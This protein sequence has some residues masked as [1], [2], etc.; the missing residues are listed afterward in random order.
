MIAAI[1]DIDGTLLPD[2][3]TDRLFLKYLFQKKIIGPSHLFRALWFMIKHIP[4]GTDYMLKKNKAYLKGVDQ[5]QVQAAARPFFYQV[6][7]PLIP[8]RSYD[9]VRD[10]Q[11]QGHTI[12]LL[13]AAYEP[14]VDLW[15]EELEADEAISTVVEE[16]HG[17]LTGTI[18]GE[19]P[20]A[21]G[22]AYWLEFMKKKY[23]LDLAQCYG[24]GDH[25]SDRFFLERV[26][27][28]VVVKPDKRLRAYARAKNWL[29]VDRL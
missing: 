15:K 4:Q 5:K 18:V 17:R 2:Y 19:H 3:S 7:Q 14:L 21:H 10:H 24:Y 27:H 23:D 20:F 8:Q 9:L 1:F 13:S 12:I 25:F 26:G 22:K 28:P 16:Q 11:F 6:I 29:I